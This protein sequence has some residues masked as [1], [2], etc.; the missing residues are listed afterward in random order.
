MTRQTSG[1]DGETENDT[2]PLQW[3]YWDDTNQVP[4]SAS[5]KIDYINAKGEN[6][7][8]NIHVTRYDG[9]VYLPAF[10]DFRQELRTYRIDRIKNCIDL[11]TGEIVAD[12]PERLLTKF[13]QTAYYLVQSDDRIR[14]SLRILF[15]IGK[16]DS[17]I[18]ANA[19]AVICEAS[20]H[21]SGNDLLTDDDINRAINSLPPPS[22]QAFKR[23][24]GK[25]LSSTLGIKIID[26]ST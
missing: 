13:C 19:R 17:Q 22:S 18:R 24:V 8:R 5:L 2:N 3:R 26:I 20:R 21:I 9:S 16:A 15:Y 12:L 14:Q 6:S 7:S 4:V 1:D 10:S 11:E 25:L 23:A